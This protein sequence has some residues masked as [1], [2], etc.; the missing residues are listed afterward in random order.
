MKRFK[1]F[2]FTIFFKREKNPY[3]MLYHHTR[4]FLPFRIIIKEVDNV[5]SLR[6][7]SFKWFKHKRIG[8]LF[9]ENR[10]VSSFGILQASGLYKGV[11][12]WQ[13][14]KKKFIGK[15]NDRMKSGSYYGPSYP[16][17]G[18]FYNSEGKK[19]YQ[20]IFICSHQGSIG[21][22]RVDFPSNYGSISW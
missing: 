15:C 19:V 2:L 14:G 9:Y 22:P 4:K 7:I 3:A 1:D 17:K 10:K 18:K 20:G 5:L 6:E 13:N 11:S 21:Y 8:F 16:V 12:Y